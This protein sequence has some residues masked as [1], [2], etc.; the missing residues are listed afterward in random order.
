MS[1]KFKLPFH[2]KIH[3]ILANLKFEAFTSTNAYFGGGTLIALL[4]D[5]YRWSKDIDF[6]CSSK[7]GYRQLRKHVSDHQ[8]GALFK[9]FEGLEFPR[10]IRRDQYGIR[11]PIKVEDEIIKFEIIFE[12][13]IE[14]DDPEFYNNFANIPC[15]SFIDR[16]AEKLLSNAD[17]WNDSSVESRDLIDLAV[18]R[19][20]GKIPDLAY[21]KAESA[22]PVVDEL[23]K[24]IKTFKNNDSYRE[25]CF[26]SLQIDKPD[27]ILKGIQLL[28]IDHNS[29]SSPQ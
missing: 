27:E 26:K 10:D 8:Y 11:F 9:S 17:R 28:E 18:L 15:L 1:S 13:R 14:L 4:Y 5:E 12:A 3:S 6:V 25:R 21:Q 19:N 7:E 2:N 16:C 20:I 22:Y 29:T 23:K 24:A